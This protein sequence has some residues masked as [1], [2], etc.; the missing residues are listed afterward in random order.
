MEKIEYADINKFMVSTGLVLMS[1]S[2]IIPYFFF[3]ESFGLYIEKSRVAVF[4]SEMRDQ[5]YLKQWALL[6]FQ[7]C[8]PWLSVGVFS[9]GLFSS[10]TGMKRWIVR[11]TKIDR[12]FDLTTTKLEREIDNLTPAQVFEMAS[13]EV[14]ENEAATR[15]NTEPNNIGSSNFP[16]ISESKAIVE[17]L[18]IEERIYSRLKKVAPKNY[19][20]LRHI[21][22]DGIKKIDMMLVS[23]D[24]MRPDVI[25]E[26]KYS[27]RII[28]MSVI[29]SAMDRLDKAITNYKKVVPAPQAIPCLIIVY[30][31]QVINTD[32]I[33]IFRQKIDNKILGA[34]SLKNIRVFFQNEF[35]IESMD[36]SLLV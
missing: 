19:E 7:S 28:S 8:L 32:Q 33:G 4:T 15:L 35:E 36:T 1:A 21:S 29:E 25:I 5:Y 27:N 9:I 17:Y 30:G 6:K 20:L 24:K 12:N 31:N 13:E 3:K 10:I 34:P 22:I 2:L 16:Q 26:V 23:K 11:Q 18:N 14:Q